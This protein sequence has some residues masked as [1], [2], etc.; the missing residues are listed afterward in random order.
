MTYRDHQNLQRHVSAD[1]LENGTDKKTEYNEA[2]LRRSASD[3]CLLESIES[4]NDVFGEPELHFEA[5]VTSPRPR[6]SS[7]T[8]TTYL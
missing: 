2:E 1:L 6:L 5:D 7:Q 8:T 3:P 4:V